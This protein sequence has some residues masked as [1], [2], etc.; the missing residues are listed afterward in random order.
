MQE[1]S[2]DNNKDNNKNHNL[3][4]ILITINNK[5]KIK[6]MMTLVMAS[7]NNRNTRKQKTTIGI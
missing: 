5:T 4:S 6:W 1:R 7:N 3:W 2:L